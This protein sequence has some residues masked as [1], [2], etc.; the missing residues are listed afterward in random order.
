[1]G[2]VGQGASG[3]RESRRE[4]T[5]WKVLVPCG[6]RWQVLQMPLLLGQISK[7]QLISSFPGKCSCH[8]SKLR[9]VLRLQRREKCG[10]PGKLSRLGGPWSCQFGRV[11]CCLSWEVSS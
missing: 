8:E 7:P 2:G 6:Q 11:T 1:M 10:H 5:A 9:A 4:A 3:R